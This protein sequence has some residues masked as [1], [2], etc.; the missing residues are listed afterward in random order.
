[1]FDD[2]LKNMDK[3]KPDAFQEIMIV[4]AIHNLNSQ[5][6]SGAQNNFDKMRDMHIIDNYNKSSFD[7]R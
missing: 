5:Q 2:R 4:N 1:M 6:Q 7:K 3:N